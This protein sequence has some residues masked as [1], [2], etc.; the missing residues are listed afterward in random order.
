M[1]SLRRVPGNA[2]L[3]TFDMK[4]SKFKRKVLDKFPNIDPS[5]K[6]LKD[7]DFFDLEK[8]LFLE[9]GIRKQFLCQIK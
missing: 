6:V 2:A 1:E 3:L 5:T 8:C 7:L 9:K 4:G